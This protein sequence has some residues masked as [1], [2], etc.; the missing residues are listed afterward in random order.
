M[1]TGAQWPTFNRRWSSLARPESCR[2]LPCS[3]PKK[4]HQSMTSCV[5][6]LSPY[7]LALV[8]PATNSANPFKPQS[9]RYA[10]VPYVLSC[11]CSI[12]PVHAI[13][14]AFAA[15]KRSISPFCCCVLQ[16]NF[17]CLSCLCLPNWHCQ[18]VLWPA[19]A[20]L[21]VATLAVDTGRLQ[22]CPHSNS[23]QAALLLRQ[24]SRS[25][26]LPAQQAQNECLCKRHVAGCVPNECAE[27][28][29]KGLAAKGADS[30]GLLSR[31]GAKNGAQRAEHE[32]SSLI[33]N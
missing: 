23:Q 16:P 22:L 5:A 11:M 30:L 9:N 24:S 4:K 10:C 26:C 8:G 32:P 27:L 12:R 1:T 17:V 25:V 33:S 31:E 13:S 7:A 21:F 6:A 28:Q 2:C 3:A 18:L 20:A 29:G 19:N 14:S 15:R